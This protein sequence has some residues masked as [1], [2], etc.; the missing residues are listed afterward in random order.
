MNQALT[1]N[2][3]KLKHDLDYA[4]QIF[5]IKIRRVIEIF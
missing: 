4:N 3:N 5:L 1:N 2:K